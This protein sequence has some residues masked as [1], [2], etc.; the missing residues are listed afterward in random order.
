MHD[1][2]MTQTL[3]IVAIVGRPNVGKSTLFN[4]YAGQRRALVED[5]PGL[6]RDRIAA[7]VEAG[8]R[9]L[10]V[11]DTAGLDPAAEE[12]LE[13]TVQRHAREA[14]E[15]ADAILFV[16]DGSSGPLPGDA[17]IAR[18]LRRSDKPVALVVN[19]IDHV[20]H[21]SRTVEF[22]SLG[23]GEPWPVSAEHGRGAWD[24]LEDLV[25]ALPADAS[26]ADRSADAKHLNVAIVGRPNVGKSSLLNR[27]VG[28]E[29]AVVSDVPGTTR[30][31]VDIEIE[32]PEGTIVL[33]DTAGLRSA[34]RRTRTAERASALMT[35]RALER[36]QVALLLLDAPDG[37][38]EGDARIAALVRDRGCAS[39]IL[40]N[41]WDLVSGDE[42][43]RSIRDEV[44]RRMRFVADAPVL[45]ISA[46]TGQRVER[47]L[48]LV[49]RLESTTTRRIPTPE[50]NRWLASTVAR[51]EPAMAQR[52]SRRRPL[53]F[54]YA[55]QTG[56]APPRF[57]LF[58]T[59]PKAVMTSYRRFLEN[60]LREDFGF[61]G[62]PLRLSLRARHRPKG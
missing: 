57:A 6:T 56:V 61:E 23:L 45:A 40:L 9:R 25:E 20:S 41:K 27:L 32:T 48:P 17:E 3:P 34:G 15:E 1:P 29:R 24:V 53:K 43:S 62:T 55:T 10:L 12:G 51:H 38:A 19:K 58:C 8:P 5:T 36:A 31:T 4:R 37:V 42:Q 16:V 50:L 46:R 35:V 7:E 14:L 47:I 21:G 52:G 30:D 54:F 26:D 13:G 2:D 59:D 44:A 39:A 11:V 33:V 28:D 60:R 18:I 49:R 22:H